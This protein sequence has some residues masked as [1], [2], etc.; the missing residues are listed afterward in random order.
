MPE[1]CATVFLDCVVECFGET[2]ALSHKK[3][4]KHFRQQV[5]CLEFAFTSPG[6]GRGADI[7]RNDP[8]SIDSQIAL[9]AF[10]DQMRVLIDLSWTTLADVN[11]DYFDTHIFDVN[12]ILRHPDVEIL[13]VTLQQG[14]YIDFGRLSESETWTFVTSVT[15]CSA[16]PPR[17]SWRAEWSEHNGNKT[18]LRLKRTLWGQSDSTCASSGEL[19]IFR[20]VSHLSE[21]FFFQTSLGC[22][23]WSGIQL[24]RYK[25]RQSSY[26]LSGNQIPFDIKTSILRIIIVKLFCDLRKEFVFMTCEDF[27]RSGK[28][29]CLES[30]VVVWEGKELPGC[31]DLWKVVDTFWVL[32]PVLKVLF[33]SISQMRKIFAV[34]TSRDHGVPPSIDCVWSRL[35]S[36]PRWVENTFWPDLCCLWWITEL[37]QTLVLLC[38]AGGSR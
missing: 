37:L 24:R 34:R 21:E 16:N 23:H 6:W 18:S 4:G 27:S 35:Q 10:I 29:N 8:L 30:L 33:L 25:E 38:G 11:N 31:Q 1:V 13:R 12:K 36:G 9:L 15:D 5:P 14:L 3:Q 7:L 22:V 19:C 20:V 26:I 2:S 28:E 17:S 32:K